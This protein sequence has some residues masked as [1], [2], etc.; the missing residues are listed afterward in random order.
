MF[1]N[2]KQLIRRREVRLRILSALSWLPDTWMVRLQYKLHTGRTLR[3]KNSQ[4][5]TEK[6]QLYKLRYRNPLMLQCTDKFEVRKVVEKVGL[7]SILIPLIGVYD[8]VEDID[9]EK[10][11][12][13][14]VAKTT[15][16]GG[17]CEVFLCRDKTKLDRTAFFRTLNAWMRMPKG[18]HPGREWAYENGFPRR[19]VIE[20]M[21]SDTVRQDLVDYK[22]FCFGGRVEYVYVVSEREL[23][24]GAKLGIYTRDFH[25][26]PVSRADERPQTETLSCPVNYLR[27]IEIAERLARPFPH[28]RIDLYNVN[29]GTIYFGE[30]TFYDGSGYM[31]FEPDSF[32]FELGK[33]F[34]VGTFV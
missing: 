11:P 29:N 23:G 5:Y 19:I 12:E 8:C 20:E 10:L 6:L 16:G 21:I 18:K 27:M 32:D 31:A 33:P 25:K 9:I 2:Y 17:G 15:D 28:A 13:Q 1:L 30:I 22:F 34:N 24:K 26:L 7:D 3:L 14:F 4:R